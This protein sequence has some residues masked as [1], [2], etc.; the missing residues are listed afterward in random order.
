MPKF[1]YIGEDEKQHR[2]YPDI[3]LK[4]E[5]KVIEVKSEYTYNKELEKNQLKKACV[6]NLNVKFEFWIF[7]KVKQEYKLTIL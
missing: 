3:Y 5:N 7:K 6:Q 4:S 1:N 2:Y